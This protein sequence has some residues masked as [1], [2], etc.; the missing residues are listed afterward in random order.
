MHDILQHHSIAWNS[1]C[2]YELTCM[3][4][5]LSRKHRLPFLMPRKQHCKEHTRLCKLAWHKAEI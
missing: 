4:L 2:A 3:P 1:T 5:R